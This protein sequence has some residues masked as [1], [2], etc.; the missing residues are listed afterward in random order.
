LRRIARNRFL[1]VGLALIALELVYLDA[2]FL[3][4]A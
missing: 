2:R 3:V 4:L 1:L